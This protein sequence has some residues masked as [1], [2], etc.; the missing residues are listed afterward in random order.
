MEGCTLF[1]PITLVYVL[2]NP[3][4]FTPEN[5]TMRMT[6]F[7]HGLAANLRFTL[8]KMLYITIQYLKYP[9]FWKFPCTV[10][11]KPIQVHMYVR[12]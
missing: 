4:N 8:A 12:C 2:K 7:T 5:C 6:S 10:Y 11:I 9:C 1:C 3:L